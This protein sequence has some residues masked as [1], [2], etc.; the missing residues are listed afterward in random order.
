MSDDVEAAIETLRTRFL[1]RSTEDLATLRLWSKHGAASD[2][3]HHRLLHRLVGSAGTFG[4]HDIS[5]RARTVEDRLLAGGSAGGPELRALITA[6]EH[7][8]KDTQPSAG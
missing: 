2:D 4:F 1:L 7:A 6:I 8:T 5:A 3:V